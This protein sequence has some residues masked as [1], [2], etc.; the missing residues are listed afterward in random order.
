MLLSQESTEAS[1][2]GKNKIMPF[3]RSHTQ[4]FSNF[5]GWWEYGYRMLKCVV[6]KSVD[7]SRMKCW[8]ALF[9]ARKS[10]Q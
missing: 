7:W 3:C 4:Y 1:V 10:N 6:R 2:N 9:K 8:S 5:T